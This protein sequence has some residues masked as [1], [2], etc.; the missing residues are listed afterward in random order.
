MVFLEGR[1][2]EVTYL[3]EISY[4]SV[5]RRVGAINQVNKYRA[6]KE[7]L[8]QVELND[9]P[10]FQEHLKNYTRLNFTLHKQNKLRMKRNL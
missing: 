10:K 9:W 1:T 8:I 7:K 5:A 2:I 6:L 4:V 3:E